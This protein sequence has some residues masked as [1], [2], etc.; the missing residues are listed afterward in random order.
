MLHGEGRLIVG[1]ETD[2]VEGGEHV[3][4]DHHKLEKRFAIVSI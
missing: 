1:F 3:L 4:A 2:G